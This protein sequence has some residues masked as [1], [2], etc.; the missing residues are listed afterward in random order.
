M[1]E[2][3]VDSK[4]DLD[5]VINKITFTN[6]V[7]DFKW[8]F[9]HRPILLPSAL[10]QHTNRTVEGKEGWLIWAEF[11]RPDILTGR[12]GV[13]RGR[14]EIILKGMSVSGVVKTCWVL[15]EMLVRHEMMEG[16]Q[17]EG[18]RIFNPHHTVEELQMPARARAQ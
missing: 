6:S 3:T 11:E 10:D 12:L 13:G 7:L 5:R 18:I 14:D 1:S 17:Y 9:R 2:P 16:F 8:K 15:F 4:E